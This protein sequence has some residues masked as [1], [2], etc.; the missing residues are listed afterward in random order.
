M[1]KAIVIKTVGDPEMAEA[2]ESGIRAGTEDA[3][4]AV[5]THDQ[6]EVV[7]AEID[8]QHILEALVR[9]AVGN[10][11]TAED[12]AMMETRA[13]ADYAEDDGRPAWL[14]RML[15]VSASVVTARACISGEKTE[16]PS[17]TASSPPTTAP[18]PMRCAGSRTARR[19]KFLS[20]PASTSWP[21]SRWRCW[22]G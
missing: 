18:M 13:R 14:R 16:N 3:R 7:E 10:T 21:V 17:A 15:P 6:I 22:H 4:R 2:I 1:M 5:L 20:A 11:K 9:V 12:Y 19:R 8:R